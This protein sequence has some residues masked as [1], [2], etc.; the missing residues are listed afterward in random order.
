MNIYLKGNYK[1]FIKLDVFKTKKKTNKVYINVH[2]LYAVSGDRGSKSKFLGN[3][4][5]EKN[6]ANVVQYSSSRDWSIFPTDG[7]YSKQQESFK[8]KTFQQEA[9]DLRDAIDLILDQSKYLFGIE[10]GKLRFYIVANSIGGTVTTTLKDKFR[11]I[12]KIVLAGSGTKPSDSTKPILST[13]PSEKEILDS[14][15]R[16]NGELLF[17]QGSKDDVVPINA[18]DKLFASYKHAKKEKVIVEGAN[19]NFSK[20]NNKDKRLAQ[21]LYTDFIIKFLS[22]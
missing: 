8:G 16:F 19:H 5:L 9:Q 7:T 10:K 22:K 17:L 2:G 20:I 3:R 21:K 12:D 14:A 4:I 11:Y 1:S 6:I 13:C 18:Q 15:T